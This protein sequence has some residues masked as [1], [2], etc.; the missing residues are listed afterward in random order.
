M[1]IIPRLVPYILDHYKEQMAGLV[2]GTTL[3]QVKKKAKNNRTNIEGPVS[4]GSEGAVLQ[5]SSSVV[6]CE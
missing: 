2:V 3:S 6:S 5:D 4:L 1:R